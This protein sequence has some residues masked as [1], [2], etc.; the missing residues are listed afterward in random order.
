MRIKKQEAPNECGLI[1]LQGIYYYFFHKW[2][3]IDE[4]KRETIFNKDGLSVAALISLGEKYNLKLEGFQV[5][6]SALEDE[7]DRFIALIKKNQQLH[8]VIF[9]HNNNYFYLLDPAI[10][11]KKRLSK[12]EFAKLYSGFLL[13]FEKNKT[14]KPIF[15]NYPSIKGWEYLFK[16][17]TLLVWTLIIILISIL[18]AFSSTIFSKIIFDKVLPNYLTKT[19][20]VLTIAFIFL[21]FCR[22]INHFLQA[23]FNKKLLNIIEI[24]L[25]LKYLK[26]YC[27]ANILNT[28]NL[29][30]SDHLHRLNL[31]PSVSIFL[32]T[33]LQVIFYESILLI[34]ATIILFWISPPLFILVFGMA[35]LLA[36]VTLIL[37]WFLKNHYQIL[38]S[39]QRNTEQFKSE[40]LQQKIKFSWVKERKYYFKRWK[41]SYEKQ[42]IDEQKIWFFSSL[43]GFFNFL[44]A[45]V[46]PLLLTYLAIKFVFA[47]E[48]SLGSMMM[49]I[50]LFNFFI[51]PL[52]NICD[53]VFRY[54][55]NINNLNLLK[56]VLNLKPNKINLQGYYGQSLK[57][58]E[59]K[60]L[61]VNLPTKIIDVSHLIIDNHVRLIGPNGCGKSVFLKTLSNIF[62][63]TGEILWND[64]MSTDWNSSYLQQKILLINN[65]EFLPTLSI[66]EYLTLN[67][68]NFQTLLKKQDYQYQISSFLQQNNLAWTTILRHNGTNISAGQRQIVILLKIFSRNFDILLLDEAFENMSLAN[69]KWFKLQIQKMNKWIIEVSHSNK[70]IVATKEIDFAKINQNNNWDLNR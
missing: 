57:R 70:I 15:K 22:A 65:E 56:Y 24:D 33:I 45:Y 55:Q 35:F 12:N 44:S 4:L 69:F 58:L 36:G 1:V 17:F 19:L 37:S 67:N 38:L 34:I 32:A 42:K 13:T 41:N 62:P 25:T 50:N 26:N 54:K 39:S 2:I 7:S 9:W 11:K 6:L 51:D 53:F 10:G 27:E 64:I 5:P 8:Y 16:N 40:L 60:N 47:N 30:Y 14:V 21:A 66:Y 48:L 49:F 59:L 61:E 28:N 3:N 18:L 68:K 63:S 20:L 43:Q 23:Y 52:I 31:I 29:V 46:W